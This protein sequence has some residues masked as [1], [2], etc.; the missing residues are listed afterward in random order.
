MHFNLNEPDWRKASR[1]YLVDL[2]PAAR[3]EW[4]CRVGRPDWI[5]LDYDGSM[6]S[7][8]EQIGHSACSVAGPDLQG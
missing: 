3:S 5:V 6:E 8:G 7:V 4:A 2:G 1:V